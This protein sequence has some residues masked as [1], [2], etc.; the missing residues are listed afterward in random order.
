[1][2]FKRA[3]RKLKDLIIRKDYLQKCYLKVIVRERR[4]FLE[5]LRGDS[6]RGNFYMFSTSQVIS[7]VVF[8]TGLLTIMREKHKNDGVCFI[9]RDFK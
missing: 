5:Y 9:R 8:I 7:I 4:F 3:K 1:M 2:D 6:V